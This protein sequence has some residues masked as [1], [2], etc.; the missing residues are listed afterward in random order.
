MRENTT[1]GPPQT[2]K[3]VETAF[4]IINIIHESDDATVAEITSQIGLSKSAV[5]KYMKTLEKQRYVVREGNSYR[6]GL[7]FL[8][9]GQNALKSRKIFEVAKPELQELAEKT[10]EMANLLVEERGCGVFV[11]KSTGQNAVNLDTYIGKEVYLHTTALGKAILAYLPEQRLNEIIEEHG[12]PMETK[13]TV[14]D[15]EELKEELTQIR[16]R[17]W[18]FDDEERLTGLRCVAVP[19]LD[20]TDDP[21]GAISVSGPKSRIEYPSQQDNLLKQ[22]DAI[23]NVIELN[24][25]YR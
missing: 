20:T 3:S 24:V 5:Y 15:T 4:Q 12:L 17:G 7:R 25:L 10:G 8:N 21:L 6:I 19:I 14:T 13:Y 1:V 18:A 11:H 2:V 16:E 22:L 9:F 23:R